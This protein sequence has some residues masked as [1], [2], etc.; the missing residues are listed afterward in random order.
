MPV[1]RGAPQE[2]RTDAIARPEQRL[3]LRSRK[4]RV[5]IVSGPNAGQVAELLGP[6]IRV[7]SRECD[8]TL[9]DMAVSRHHLTLRVEGGEIRVLDAGSKNGTT[10][11]GV[12]IVEAFA[13]PDSSIS[14][15]NSVLRLR[16]LDDVVE[17]PL[18]P[19]TQFGG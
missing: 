6:E 11:D 1:E 9:L 5:E 7:G 4:I 10:L 2:P 3:T 14:V 15:G 13:R 12:R 8:L 16:L 19:S 18:S 17:L